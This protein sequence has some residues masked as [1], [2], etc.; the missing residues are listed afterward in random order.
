M[1]KAEIYN[2]FFENG[3]ILNLYITKDIF[4]KLNRIIT[5][6]V[7]IAAPINPILLIKIIL[8]KIT[9]IADEIEKNGTV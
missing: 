3:W 4:R 1:I 8:K 7:D 9:A 5:I 6:I 2:V